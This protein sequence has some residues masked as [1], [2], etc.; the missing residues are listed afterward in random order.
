MGELLSCDSIHDEC[1][2]GD[3]LLFHYEGGGHLV[4]FYSGKDQGKVPY[5]YI[6]DI[7]P[8]GSVD[9][10]LSSNCCTLKPD[11][12]KSYFISMMAAPRVI[13]Y[14]ILR[15]AE[16]KEILHVRS[17][18]SN[19]DSMLDQNRASFTNSIPKL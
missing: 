5:A 19:L 4:G 16:Q 7:D 6:R 14:E 10:T 2:P 13:G 18:Q 15:R 17:G 8:E 1:R 3:I 11:H 9:L 12:E